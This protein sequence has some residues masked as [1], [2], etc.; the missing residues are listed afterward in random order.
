MNP[1]EPHPLGVTRAPTGAHVG[2]F[3]A[4]AEAA[5]L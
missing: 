3:S 4:H 1:E 2:V 5:Y